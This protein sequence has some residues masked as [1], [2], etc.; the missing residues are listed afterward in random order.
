VDEAG[1][2]GKVG[3][4]YHDLPQDRKHVEP[5]VED[6]DRRLKAGGA[7]LHE[8][9]LEADV[10][11]FLFQADHGDG[12]T[13]YGPQ[14]GKPQAPEEASDGDMS[15]DNESD[16]DDSIHEDDQH[17]QK[18]RPNMSESSSSYGN[19][20]SSDGTFDPESNSDDGN[21]DD[22]SESYANDDHEDETS[23]ITDDSE[24]DD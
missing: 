2:N 23:N 16:N 5:D 4:G 20:R 8:D 11:G 19:D 3:G 14:Y 10:D 21:D 7:L 24:Y 22:D 15:R 1:R 18:S 9:Q 12:E 17:S 6:P 13:F